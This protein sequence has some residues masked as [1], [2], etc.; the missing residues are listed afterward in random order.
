MAVTQV[1]ERLE[2]E[3]IEFRD[4]YTSDMLRMSGLM[5]RFTGM[6]EQLKQHD[7]ILIRGNGVPSLQE[8]MRDL[9]RT[10]YDYINK[11][12]EEEKRA[13][14]RWDKI[15]VGIIIGLGIPFILSV[16]QAIVL[17]FRIYPILEALSKVP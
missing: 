10:V 4:R 7:K 15:R 8:A 9:S 6:E 5:E 1:I 16:I 2:K 11:K 3:F 17:I 12:N 14:E 13:A